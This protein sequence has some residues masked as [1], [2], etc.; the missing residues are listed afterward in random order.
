MSFGLVF[1]KARTESTTED[2][3]E[4]LTMS[5][6]A[7][8]GNEYSDL[9]DSEDE[10]TPGPE[11]EPA[12]QYDRYGIG[13]K[14][15]MKM[16]YQ[17]GEGLGAEQKG[18]VNPIETKLRPQGLG[19]GGINEKVKGNDHKAAREE[20]PKEKEITYD[21]FSIIEELELRGCEVPLRYKELSDSGGDKDAIKEAF[22]KL[23]LVNDEWDIVTKQ[24]KY[25]Q[26]SRQSIEETLKKQRKEIQ[27]AETILSVLLTYHR[28][29]NFESEDFLMLMVK[30]LKSVGASKLLS[31]ATATLFSAP[32][33]EVVA[34]LSN[35]KALGSSLG[36]TGQLIDYQNMWEDLN[37]PS[38]IWDSLLS[39]NLGQLFDSLTDNNAFYTE[40]LHERVMDFFLLWYDSESMINKDAFWKSFSRTK[41]LPFLEKMVNAWDLTSNESLSPTNYFNEYIS[42]LGWSADDSMLQPYLQK[43][44]AKYSD[45]V[46]IE[47]SNSLWIQSSVSSIVLNIKD[48]YRICKPLFSLLLHSFRPEDIED[49]LLQSLLTFSL[50][51]KFTPKD[52]ER[53][54]LIITLIP[55]LKLNSE[56]ELIIFQFAICNPWIKS[57]KGQENP[58]EWLDFWLKWVV[59]LKPPLLDVFE[60]YF[61]VATASPTNPILPTIKENPFPSSSQIF[62]LIH[63][64]NDPNTS[65]KPSKFNVEGIPSYQLMTK[66]KDVIQD[67]CMDLDITFT[68]IPK[69]HPE[70]G[71]PLYELRLNS[72]TKWQ[73]FIQDDVLWVSSSGSFE[74]MSLNELKNYL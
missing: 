1:A 45:Y 29:N 13:A 21:L 28:V 2:G 65:T 53:L 35:S 61:D 55:L 39:Q 70:N 10:P 24:E 30:E 56:Q 73:A 36:L 72:G 54:E 57:M 5:M 12:Q 43:V 22:E 59:Q 31:E 51:L 25:L 49:V 40:E 16:G 69:Y 34:S 23:K 26:F 7:R 58:P 8:V 46:N 48:F 17:Q 38:D 44:Y 52:V 60:W 66:F 27:D 50:Q 14:L 47:S 67:Y 4:E 74:P 9:E 62:E 11:P 18:I 64:Y 3:V 37:V 71:L 20:K 33:A 19:V 6:M 41:I 32:V 63:D 15:M 42:Q 68:S